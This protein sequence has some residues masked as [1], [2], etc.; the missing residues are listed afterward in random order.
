MA[1]TAKPYASLGS[2]CPDG[3]VMIAM[4]VMDRHVACHESKQI[5]QWKLQIIVLDIMQLG[6][7][8]MVGR[9]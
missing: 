4:A 2:G 1:F 5:V 8:S 6:K 9:I 3:T 7:E